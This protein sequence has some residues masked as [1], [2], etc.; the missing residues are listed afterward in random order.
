MDNFHRQTNSTF[1]VKKNYYFIY[2]LQ[3]WYL[4]F[5]IP[6]TFTFN[7]CLYQVPTLYKRRIRP[8][9]HPLPKLQLFS[10]LLFIFIFFLNSIIQLLGHCQHSFLFLSNIFFFS[11]QKNGHLLKPL[12]LCFLEICTSYTHTS[13]FPGKRNDTK[14]KRRQV[15]AYFV[16][17][18]FITTTTT[19]IFHTG[20]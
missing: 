10:Y 13:Y 4:Y 11:K 1:I 5:H 15:S 3:T 14:E 9:I 7:K 17:P 19:S 16:L 2:T 8:L 20:L 18:L 12:D 6:R